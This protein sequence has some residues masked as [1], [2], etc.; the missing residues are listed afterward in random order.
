MEGRIGEREDKCRQYLQYFPGALLPSL[1]HFLLRPPAHYTHSIRVHTLFSGGAGT[2]W[3]ELCPRVVPGRFP[4]QG[5]SGES[6]KEPEPA[7][8]TRNKDCSSNNDGLVRHWEGEFGRP[9][10]SGEGLECNVY[11]PTHVACLCLF[12]C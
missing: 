11:I 7:R 2:V 8:G 6:S 12:A 5:R 4:N 10:G 9:E 3:R 1:T